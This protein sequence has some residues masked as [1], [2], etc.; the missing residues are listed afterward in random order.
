MEKSSLKYSN[1]FVESFILCDTCGQ[2]MYRRYNEL[3]QK[4]IWRCS[5]PECPES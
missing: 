5:N 3:V 1:D 4:H 2:P